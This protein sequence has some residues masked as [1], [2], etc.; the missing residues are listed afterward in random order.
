MVIILILIG[1]IIF[2]LYIN[3]ENFVVDFLLEAT[4]QAD[5][6]W[7]DTNPIDVVYTW[8]GPREHYHNEIKYSIL[9]LKKFM[10]WVSNI[11]VFMNDP[12]I[13]PDWAPSDVKFISH[14]EIIDPKYLPTTSSFAIET[15]IS[16]LPGLSSRFI[17]FNDDFIVIKSLQPDYFFDAL[18]RPKVM[19][20]DTLKQKHSDFIVPPMYSG[21]YPHTALPLL[22]SQL[23][24]HNETYKEYIDW[25]RSYKT[26]QGRNFCEKLNGLSFPCQHFQITISPFMYDNGSAIKAI[27]TDASS[28]CSNPNYVNYSCLYKLNNEMPGP[29]IVIQ[30]TVLNEREDLIFTESI[31]TYFKYLLD[32]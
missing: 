31:D 12:K 29:I 4:G 18:G 9:C 10:P 14:S 24:L 32:L 17:Y 22:K 28:D 1:L 21:F 11:Y 25:I 19:I 16:S 5:S 2:C 8:A 30:D 3:Q 13:I 20:F 26:R 6:I 23:I 15:Y 27:I 7:R